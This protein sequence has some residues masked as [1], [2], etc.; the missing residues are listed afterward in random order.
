VKKKHGGLLAYLYILPAF[1]VMGIVVYYPMLYN[2]VLSLFSERVFDVPARFV[3]LGNYLSVLADRDVYHAIYLTIAWTFLLTLLQY[4][5]G[6]IAALLLDTRTVASRASRG[7]Y[8]LPWIVPAVVTAIAFRFMYN[9][10]YGLINTTLRSIGLRSLARAWIAT[11]E[12]AFGAIIVLGVWKGFPFYMLML[13]AGLQTIPHD[14]VDAARIDGATPFGVFRHIRMPFLVPVT[15][16]S[17]IL[18]IIWTANYFDG[19]YLL[20]GGGPAN[21]TTTLP[22]YIYQTAFSSFDLTRASTVSILLLVMVVTVA[23]P[24]VAITR[25]RAAV[26]A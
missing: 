6:L 25:K 21:A 22:I 23:I 17:L 26:N 16:S 12:T 7:F 1:L 13:L 2:V 8:I 15:L 20:T 11:P 5:A 18:G 3:G 19:I 24:Y 4:C 14:L 9:F 10:D